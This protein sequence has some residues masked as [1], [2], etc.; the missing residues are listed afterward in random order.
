MLWRM[1]DDYVRK[2]EYRYHSIF[3]QKYV[4]TSNNHTMNRMPVTTP[5]VTRQISNT[6]YVDSRPC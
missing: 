6:S 3:E 1:L 5:T 4:D 2:C